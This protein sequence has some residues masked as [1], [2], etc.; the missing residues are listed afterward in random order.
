MA[1][2][3]DFVLSHDNYE[4]TTTRSRYD[5]VSKKQN[6]VL[7]FSIRLRFTSIRNYNQTDQ[8]E[9]HG[10]YIVRGSHFWISQPGLLI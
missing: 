6:I 8:T 3:G 10:S 5:K 1:V 7:V 9:L 2:K 4:S